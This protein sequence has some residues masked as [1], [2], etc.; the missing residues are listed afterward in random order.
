[1]KILKNIGLVVISLFSTYFTLN[2][3]IFL[4]D[5]FYNVVIPGG[6][7]ATYEALGQT[8]LGLLLGYIFFTFFF[9]VLFGDRHKYW[10]VGV[11]QLPALYFI[12]QI[13]LAHWYFY[14]GLA[15]AGYLLATLILVIRR[16]FRNN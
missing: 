12:I 2:S 10:W 6:Y 11:L 9:F 5:K 1:M 7:F 14:A 15:I 3:F 16:Q 8:L 13:D 4:Y